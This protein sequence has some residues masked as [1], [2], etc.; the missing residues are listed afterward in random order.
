MSTS[1]F[2]RLNR[3][4][5]PATGAFFLAFIVG[6]PAWAA[7]GGGQ[8]AA[9]QAQPPTWAV[10]TDKELSYTYLGFTTRYS[11]DGLRD[12]IRGVLL[13]LGAD[14]KT[15][16]V[17]QLGC[18]SPTGRPDP[19]PGVRVRMKV[20]QAAGPNDTP[21]AQAH[22]KPIDL[23]LRDSFTTDSGECELMEQI[24]DKILPL[25]ATRNVDYK[26]DCIPHQASATRPSLKL[27]VLW[28]DPPQPA[29]GEPPAA[30]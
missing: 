24:R 13:D 1:I 23:K 10:W 4:L 20:V 17:L 28:P 21:T 16:K 26:A 18:S 7:E 22:W 5:V 15:L 25:F 12:K 6:S 2:H 14:K 11:C 9:G 29:V 3:W 30:Q 27:E 19:F 8:A